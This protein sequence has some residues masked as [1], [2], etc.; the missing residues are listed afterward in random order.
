MN[1]LTRHV[2]PHVIAL[3][4]DQSF[5]AVLLTDASTGK[6]GHRIVYVNEAFRRMTGYSEQ[7]L[8]GRNPRML[9]GAGTNPDVIDRLR[10][11][12]REGTYF[13]GSTVNYRKDGRPYTVEWNISP[14]RNSAGEI[15]HFISVQQ[16]ISNLM[17]AQKTTQLFA[18]VLNATD[19][20]VVITDSHGAI[21]FANKGFENITGY[22]LTEVLGRNPSMLKSGEQDEAFYQSMWKTLKTGSTFRSTFIN[23]AKNNELIHCDETITPLTNEEGEVTHYVSIFRDLTTRVL[24]EQKFREMVRFDGLTGALNRA[25]GELALEK[26]YMQ[27]LGSKVPMSIAMADIDHFKQVNDTWGHSCGDA[28]LKALSRSLI[29]TLRANDSVIRWGG[30]E[31]LLIFSGCDL[32]QALPLAERCRAGVQRL[33]H[34]RV[35]QV[36]LSMGVGELRT[37]ETL[38][39]LIER[40]DQALY[41]AK[42]AGRNRVQVSTAPQ[43]G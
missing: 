13:H 5:N 30:E 15:T 38:A 19:D 22:G 31:F 20:G 18:H 37:G 34:E 8:L 3:A 33:T 6:D 26:A 25:S 17:A 32:D 4:L 11:C 12:L 39:H 43:G 7:E 1:N 28:V 14:V 9:Q 21:E 2:E 40:V 41:S 24:E 10:E 42:H 27:C 36:T 29:A 23:R 35:G 16:D